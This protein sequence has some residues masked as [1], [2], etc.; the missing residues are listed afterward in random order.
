MLEI[1]NLTVSIEGNTILDNFNLTVKDG[2]SRRHHGPERHR[3][4]D[5]RLCHRRQA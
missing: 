1:K 4:V 2:G 5:A 3:Q